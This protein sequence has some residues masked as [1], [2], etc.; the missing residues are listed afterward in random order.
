M[1][2]FIFSLLITVLTMPI[3]AGTKLVT[4]SLEELKNAKQIPVVLNWDNAVYAKAGTL[5]NFLDKAVRNN[6]WEKGSISYLFQKLNSKTSEYGI[7][8]V[9]PTAAPDAEYSIEIIVTNISKGGD[10]KGEI[11][12]KKKG[13]AEPL[14]L[15]AFISD[16]A[17]D[18]DKIAFRDQFKTIGESLSKLFVKQLKQAYK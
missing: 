6:D 9:E 18:D 2:K 4:G 3:F 16:D 1:K 8:F 13:E 12:F 10:L 5:T 17:D 7:R 14:A 15:M 11:L